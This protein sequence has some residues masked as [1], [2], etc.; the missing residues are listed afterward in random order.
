MPVPIPS[1]SSL[2]RV[3]QNRLFRSA[4][5]WLFVV[6][7]AASVLSK[8]GTEYTF[9]IRSHAFTLHLQLPFSWRLFYFS[10]CAFA[11]G[12][13]FFDLFAPSIVK[14]YHRFEDWLREGKGAVELF[15]LAWET[16]KTSSVLKWGRASRE[17]RRFDDFCAF[18]APYREN[19]QPAG[20]ELRAAFQHGNEIPPGKIVG[21]DNPSQVFWWVW[22]Y[23]DRS[24]P[25][26]RSLITLVYALAAF[27]TLVVLCQNF[28]YV[29]NLSVPGM[30][31]PSFTGKSSE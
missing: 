15:K 17:K 1:W 8:V 5:L 23:S 13:F 30:P 28:V 3:G 6:P 18:V 9:H 22:E 14:R 10:A 12:T 7:I 2:S 29:W 24:Q 4:Y 16:I 20:Q 27:L 19:D 21:V 11:A 26:V 25:V 31:L